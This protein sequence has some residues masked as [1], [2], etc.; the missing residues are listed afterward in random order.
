M[1]VFLRQAEEILEIAVHGNQEV[2]IAIDRQGGV[3][4]MDPTGWSLPSMRLEYGAGFVYKVER[5]GGVLRVEGWDG[6]QRCVLE[7]RVG[8]RPWAYLPGMPAVRRRLEIAPV[9]ITP[10]HQPLYG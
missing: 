7:K 10:L 9:A 6:T 8:L 1:S 5:H 3:R 2:A 4:M